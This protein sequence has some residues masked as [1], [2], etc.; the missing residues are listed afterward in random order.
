MEDLSH[1]N[2]EGSVLRRAQMKMLEMLD[3]FDGICRKHNINYWLVCGT[4][5]GARR[6]GGFIPWDDDLDVAVLKTDYKKLLSILKEELPEIF[7]LQARETDK[8]YYHYYARIRD[9]KSRFY[10]NKGRADYFEYKGIFIDIFFIEPV[11]SMEFKKIIDKFLL[12]GIHFARAKSLYLKIKYAIMFCFLPIIH[13]II[14]LSRFYY[15]YI[16]NSKAY[17]YAYGCYPY[18]KY[19]MEYFFPVSE[20]LFEGKKYK[21]PH[22]IDKYLT[23]NFGLDFMDIPKAADR[24]THSTNIEF[25]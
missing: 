23:D 6:H 19:N 22:D 17:A 12:S 15:K 24:M 9:T 1:Y 14:K 11:P 5:L 2:P 3:V 10:R 25:L 21:A 16:S 4:L 13:F 8:K 7:K 20:I 18:I